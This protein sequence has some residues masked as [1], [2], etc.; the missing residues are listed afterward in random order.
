MRQPKPSA[1]KSTFSKH[2]V[3]YSF[4]PVLRQLTEATHTCCII[5]PLLI[6]SLH[7]RPAV[8]CLQHHTCISAASPKACR[9]NLIQELLNKLFFLLNP[10]VKCWRKQTAPVLSVLITDSKVRQIT[11]TTSLK[12]CALSFPSWSKL[13][14]RSL[15]N[16]QRLSILQ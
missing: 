15:L 16:D 13:F 4:S 1:P 8:G 2:P 9:I 3:V 10:Q 14:N 7:R 12:L 6:M 5:Y 11:V